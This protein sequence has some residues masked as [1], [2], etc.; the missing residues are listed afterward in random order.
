LEFSMTV[1]ITSPVTG[2]AQTGLT[3]PTY[4]LTTDVAPNAQ[5]KQQAVTALGGTQTNVRTH[6]AS[7][8]FTV[9]IERPAVIRT[10]PILAVGATLPPVPRNTYVL[11]VRKGVICVVGQ[12]SQPCL[13]E[14]RLNIPAGSDLNDPSN[15]RAAVSLLIGALTQVSAGLGDTVV[16]GLI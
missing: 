4:T 12:A 13:I 15:L 2:S 8:P 9:T 11:R 16:Q 1:S 10:V 5:G 6:S 7:D 3:S 14:A